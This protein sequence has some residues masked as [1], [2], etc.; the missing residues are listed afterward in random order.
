MSPLKNL[1]ICFLAGTLGKGGAER[2]LYYNIKALKELDA[3]VYVLSLDKNGYWKEKI[4]ALD[5]KVIFVGN[6]KIRLI[7]LIIT[8]S[9]LFYISPNIIQSQHFYTNIYA[10]IA[11]S[12]LRKISIGAVRNKFSEENKELKSKFF[13]NLNLFGLDYIFINS[14]SAYKEVKN[15]KKI[16]SYCLHYPNV[17]DTNEFSIKN[18]N[19]NND[20][21]NILFVGSLVRRKRPDVFIK[22][23]S[24]LVKTGNDNI[25]GILC[26]DGPEYYKLKS[27]A[28]YLGL[29]TDYISF[30]G[31]ISNMNEIYAQADILLVTSEFEGTSNVVLEAMCSGVPVISNKVGDVPYIIQSE[32]TGI[33]INS[34]NDIVEFTNRVNLLLNDRQFSKVISKNAHKYVTSKFSFYN[35]PKRLIKCYG[36]ILRIK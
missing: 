33:I 8:T 6:S 9:H 18:N 25:H 29:D 14:K 10:W 22:I 7:R 19:Y 30:K 24:N 23:I 17:I 35:L 2:Q 20:K 27:Q 16:H 31:E 11:A 21:T 5:V 4:E 3:E 32:K 1:K 26:G 13:K 34:T 36:N 15:N 28:K 12:I